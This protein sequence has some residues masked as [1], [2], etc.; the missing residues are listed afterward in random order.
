M[1]RFRGIFLPIMP[2]HS[3]TERQCSDFWVDF[4]T[5]ERICSVFQGH[6]MVIFMTEWVDS[7]VLNWVGADFG[8]FER[9]CSVF[10]G[11]SMVIL[12]T[13]WVD[14]DVLNWVEMLRFRQLYHYIQILRHT[15]ADTHFLC[16]FR[17]SRDISVFTLQIGTQHL[18]HH[19][20]SNF[21]PESYCVTHRTL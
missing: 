17:Q 13:E 6:S 9:I 2:Y 3:S 7:D 12:M 21:V 19:V 5:F 14:S 16:I 18:C 15:R 8:T 4:G 1:L 20:Q 10:Q 11:H